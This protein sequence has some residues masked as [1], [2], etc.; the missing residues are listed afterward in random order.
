MYIR[1]NNK[2]DIVNSVVDTA[3]TTILIEFTF[4]FG[5]PLGGISLCG[6]L[7]GCDTAGE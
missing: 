5:P 4:T 7:G 6:I 3:M 2:K 1:I